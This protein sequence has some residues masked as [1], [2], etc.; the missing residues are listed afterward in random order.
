M[1]QII[2]KDNEAG[3]RLDKM[4]AK[5]LNEAPKSFLYKM[6]RKKNITLNGK[7]AAGNEKLVSGDEVKLFLSDE[8]IARFSSSLVQYT[9][10]KLDI[11]YEDENILLINKPAGML[12]QKA[13]DSDESVVEHLI[14]YLLTSGQLSEQDLKTFKPSVCN[15]LDRNTSG[16]I[17]AGK[18]LKGLQELSRLFKDRT[19][20]KYYLC[21]AAG[22]ITEPSRIQ[23]YLAKDEKTNQVTVRTV[24]TDGADPIETEYRPLKADGDVTLLEV[25]LITGKTHQIR[26]HLASVGHPVI[27][28]Y[29]YGNRNVND[30]YRKAY[31][32]EHQLLH[33][34]RLIFPELKGALSNLSQKEFIAPLTKEFCEIAADK[35]VL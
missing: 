10:E 35:G 26:A 34:Y 30:S 6:L 12:S 29:K 23:G 3:Q 14:T 11:L 21:L 17:A 19:L 28:D 27:G 32:L 33:A 18:S 8:T 4:L 7:K 13:V 22:N 9:K 1:Q 5:Y 16:M 20:G 31:G 2:I 25:H 24:K 15:R